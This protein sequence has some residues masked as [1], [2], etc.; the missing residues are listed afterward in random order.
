MTTNEKEIYKV[1]KAFEEKLNLY[2]QEVTIAIDCFYSYIKIHNMMA[3]N[4]KLYME[5]NKNS[6]F[7]N[8]ISHSLQATLFITLGRIFDESRKSHSIFHILEYCK[9]QKVIF[10]NKQFAKRKVKEVPDINIEEY[11]EDKDTELVTNDDFLIFEEQINICKGVYV[12][13]YKKIRNKI[14]GHKDLKTIGNEDKL[15]SKTLIGELKKILDLLDRI[16]LAL[17]EL[18]HNGIKLDLNSIRSRNHQDIISEHTKNVL[19]SLP[20]KS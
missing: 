19:N 15:F 2:F 20:T 1:S 17:W 3:E 9:G 5:L 10:L 4:K 12:K 8:T 6:L 14:Y 18:Y 16:Y 13:N 11:M 7:W